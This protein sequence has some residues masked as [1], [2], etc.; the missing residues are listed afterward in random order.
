LEFGQGTVCVCVC[1]VTYTEPNTNTLRTPTK[2]HAI[3]D[4]FSPSEMTRRYD[5]CWMWSRFDFETTFHQRAHRL[6]TAHT[7]T[8]GRTKHVSMMGEYSGM[9]KNSE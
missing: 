4:A 3:L 5:S 6:L 1:A 8:F 9:G 2:S 7:S